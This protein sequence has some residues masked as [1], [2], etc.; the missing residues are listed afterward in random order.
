TLDPMAS[1]VLPMG[2]NQA[3]R[4][5]DYLLDKTKT[6]VAE[7]TFG[8]ETDTLDGTGKVLG[9]T[10]KT[11]TKDEIIAVLPEFI[12]EI[13]QIPPKFSAKCLNGKRGYQLARKGV[14]FSLPSKK[15]TVFSFELIEK[16]GD[17]SYKFRISCKGGTYIRSLC[18]DV[19]ERLSSKAVMTALCRESAGVFDMKNGIDVDD[20][21]SVENIAD[22]LIGSDEVIFFPKHVISKEQ[23]TRLVNGLFTDVY[24]VP[25]GVYRVYAETD[26]WGVGEIKGKT[27]KMRTY[28]RD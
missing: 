8:Y 25:D 15:V 18:R 21:K 6:Y 1:G 22:C 13:D 12:G 20:F 2:I 17:N 11:P 4:L 28:V 10:D 26:F 27:L 5:F 14:D 24:D 23:A 9:T 19:A 7:F 16:T 3:N